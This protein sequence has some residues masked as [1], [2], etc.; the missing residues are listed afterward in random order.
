[1]KPITSEWFPIQVLSLLILFWAVIPF[2]LGA[3]RPDLERQ[4][5]E[6][7]LN[8]PDDRA[9]G[10]QLRIH[11]PV[12]EDEI[13][14]LKEQTTS[15][16]LTVRH[17]AA[18]LLSFARTEKVKP[19]LEELVNKSGD[20][21][22]VMVALNR[23]LGDPNGQ[24]IA[25]QNSKKIEQALTS[26]DPEVLR[27]SLKAGMIIHSPNLE[28]HLARGLLQNNPKVREAALEVLADI[29]PSSFEPQIKE[30]LLHKKEH[31]DDSYTTLY[32]I[33]SRSDDPKMKEVFQTS[34]VGA[35]TSQWLDFSNGIFLSKSRKPWLKALLLDLIHRKD[36][37]R[38][39]A[40]GRL[41]DFGPDVE[42]DLMKVC[43]ALYEKEI[44]KL[45]YDIEKEECQKFVNKLAGKEYTFQV[46]DQEQTLIFMKQW[47]AKH[48]TTPS[49]KK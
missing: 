10:K 8:A 38:W 19:M 6:N 16:N 7:L 35:D 21:Y 44:P 34:L 11:G 48:P 20:S 46:Q 22:V 29:G 30:A 41:V 25:L 42:L 39:I 47:L 23:L 5:L 31:P 26:E 32:Q 45:G 40:F 36:M 27:L 33:L 9:F 3:D 24:T 15:P 2:P 18:L 17:N 12:V 49:K 14:Y 4:I 13:L 43:L 1:M 28:K 37:A